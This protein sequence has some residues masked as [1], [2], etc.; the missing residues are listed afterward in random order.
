MPTVQALLK[1]L[2]YSQ[3]SILDYF[4]VDYFASPYK[5]LSQLIDSKTDFCK[6]QLKSLISF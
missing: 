6:K 1:G 2:D 4:F 3:R 5:L